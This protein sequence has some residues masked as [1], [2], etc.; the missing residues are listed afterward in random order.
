MHFTALYA[1]HDQDDSSS[2]TEHVYTSPCHVQFKDFDCKTAVCESGEAGSWM[3][4]LELPVSQFAPTLCHPLLWSQAAGVKWDKGR[5]LEIL[6]GTFTSAGALEQSGIE[7]LPVFPCLPENP[8]AFKNAV[9]GNLRHSLRWFCKFANQDADEVA[10]LQWIVLLLLESGFSSKGHASTKIY[11]KAH[12]SGDFTRLKKSAGILQRNINA[13][14]IPSGGTASARGGT[15]STGGGT[16]SARAGGSSGAG[17]GAGHGSGSG[18][19]DG[20]RGSAL[21]VS[22][23][24]RS[25]F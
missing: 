1:L 16:A 25:V 2:L 24:V 10:C 19:G 7:D 14:F 11:T 8:D 13:A 15:A 21:K 22:R 9:H 18:A 5:I 6:G 3:L 12:S 20:A 17:D 4:H 23:R